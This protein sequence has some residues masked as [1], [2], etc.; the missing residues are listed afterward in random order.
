MEKGTIASQLKISRV[1][2]EYKKKGDKSDVKSYRI[3]AISSVILRIYE[4]AMK[5]KLME[6]IDPQISNAQHGFRPRRSVT[7]NLLNL[8]TI[9]NDAFMNEQ[10]VD[11]F[12]GDFANAFDKVIHR[13]LVYKM[14][15][16]KIGKKT[17]KW[18]FEFVSGRKF[19]VQI[20]RFK[21]R[22]YVAT[23]GVPAGSVLGPA[24]FLIFID[25]IKECVRYAVMLLFADDVKMM[26]VVG[27]MYE[28]RCLQMDIDNVLQ[29]SKENCLPLN[30]NK[31]NVLTMRRTREFY[32]A[33]YK[34]GEHEIERKEEICDLGILV[35][36]KGTYASHIEQTTT[37]A[38]QSMGYIKW[39][40]KGQFS[41]QTL[42][43]LYTSYVRSKLEFG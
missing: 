10:Q 22:I 35:N 11:L 18:M 4:I 26:M 7:T 2:P 14:K 1:V 34:L 33:I 23:S 43:I 41:A 32:N 40:S 3:T 21:S 8:S 37:K 29:W 27:S 19:Y 6:I 16:F 28:T 30:P 25:D 24:L 12:Y 9:S 5:E 13:I 31:C 42:K 39:I 20:G 15:L 17:A 36:V 38:R